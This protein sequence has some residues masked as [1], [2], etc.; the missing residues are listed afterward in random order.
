MSEWMELDMHDDISVEEIMKRI[1]DY[2]AEHR[3]RQELDTGLAGDFDLQGT[4]VSD[5][6]EHM[7]RAA[8]A[9][10][11]IALAVDIRRSHVPILGPVID[12]LR[13]SLHQLVLFY[14]NRSIA[15]QKAINAD[16]LQALGY[17][18]SEAERQKAA[19]APGPEPGETETLA[20]ETEQR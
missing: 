5:F 14:V 11:D 4:L 20:S 8:R 17:L 15:M 10:K 6:Y 1:Q 9:N 3:T 19:G 2:I 18:A 12:A 7:G 16:L 13:G